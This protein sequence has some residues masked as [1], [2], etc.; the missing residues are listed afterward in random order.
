MLK[1]ITPPT[2]LSANVNIC[3]TPSLLFFLHSFW[4]APCNSHMHRQVLKNG[5]SYI[6]SICPST[7]KSFEPTKWNQ[8]DVYLLICQHIHMNCLKFYCYWIKKMCV[9]GYFFTYSFILLFKTI[10]FVW[11]FVLP[12]SWKCTFLWVFR[13]FYPRKCLQENVQSIIQKILK[14]IVLLVISYNKALYINSFFYL[15]KA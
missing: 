10:F 2:P 4:T 13:D 1:L 7:L 5:L 12:N 3:Q 8:Y 9:P 6:S 15:L 11:T 14:V